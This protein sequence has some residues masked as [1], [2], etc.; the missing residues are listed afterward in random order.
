MPNTSS[1]QPARIPEQVCRDLPE[2]VS[3]ECR[4]SPTPGD[5]LLPWPLLSFIVRQPTIHQAPPRSPCPCAC[6]GLGV[7]GSWPSSS[8]RP[9]LLGRSGYFLPSDVFFP[10]PTYKQG[11]VILIIAVQRLTGVALCGLKERPEP[12]WDPRA[13]LTASHHLSHRHTDQG[14]CRTF[15][16]SS[17][18]EIGL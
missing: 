18:V 17:S 6:H 2:H 3:L 11:A 13:L 8:I 9:T 15:T 12:A 10:L 4:S 5:C 14:T 16:A 1:L 7:I